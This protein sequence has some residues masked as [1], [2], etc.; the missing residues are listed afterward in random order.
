M[1]PE[2]HHAV[3]ESAYFKLPETLQ[4]FRMYSISR[5]VYV[6]HCLA[7]RLIGLC[8]EVGSK[9]PVFVGRDLSNLPPVSAN[10][11]DVASLMRD[12]EDMKL[13][14]LGL[15]DMSRL[16]REIND[17]V[18]SITNVRPVELERAPA[19]VDQSPIDV[20]SHPSDETCRRLASVREDLPCYR[21]RL[22]FIR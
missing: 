22:A 8:H 16:S 2:W 4:T 18:N 19:E 17:A 21:R 6:L 3:P 9:L 1:F 12:I 11:F 20:G 5:F 15:A 10:S 14:L 7:T 13:Q